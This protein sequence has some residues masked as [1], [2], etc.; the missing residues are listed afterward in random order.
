MKSTPWTLAVFQRK[1]GRLITWSTLGLGRFNVNCRLKHAATGQQDLQKALDLSFAKAEL[2]DLMLCRPQPT[3]WLEKVHLD[4]RFQD[5]QLSGLAPLV[6][7]TLALPESQDSSGTVEIA[8]SPLRPQ[9]FFVVDPGQDLSRQ[10]NRFFAV[11]W[12]E[13]EDSEANTLLTRGHEKLL[14]VNAKV[15]WRGL[16]EDKAARADRIGLGRRKREKV[17]SLLADDLT[18]EIALHPERLDV[19]P[20]PL[21]TDR[22][23]LA[24]GLERWP[25]RFVRFGWSGRLR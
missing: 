13:I 8:Y 11:A 15:S 16:G 18:G 2:A 17:L 25:S 19:L 24:E 9:D 21:A 20:S 10:A 14:L 7:E 3:A 4:L 12:R 1:V 6:I 5:V 22:A 23:A